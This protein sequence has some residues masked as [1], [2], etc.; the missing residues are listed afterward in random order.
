MFVL[1]IDPGLSTTGYAVVARERR[2][3]RPVAAGAIRTSSR[4]AIERRLEEL[5]RDLIDLIAEHGP[6]EMAIERVFVNNN[7]QTATSVGRASG[8]ILLAAA[9]AGLSVTEYTPTAIKLAVAGDGR[10]DKAQ[11]QKALVMRLGLDAAPSPADASDA[12]AIALCHLQ[13]FGLQRKIEA[14]G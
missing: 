13:A 9:Q 6:A 12:L 1:G 11:V 14:A 4:D 5:H 2:G 3:I 8:V 10:A 7:L